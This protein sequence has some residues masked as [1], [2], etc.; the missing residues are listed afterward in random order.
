MATKFGEGCAA[1]ILGRVEPRFSWCINVRDVTAALK[2]GGWRRAQKHPFNGPTNKWTSLAVPSNRSSMGQFVGE[3]KNAK[4]NLKGW[5]L[6]VIVRC[7]QRGFSVNI[8]ERSLLTVRP[9]F[10]QTKTYPGSFFFWSPLFEIGPIEQSEK[11]HRTATLIPRKNSSSV[12]V[13]HGKC[14]SRPRTLANTAG[15]LTR[16]HYA[17][18]YFH[19]RFQPFFFFFK[20]FQRYESF[21]MFPKCSLSTG[22]RLCG[23]FIFWCN[24]VQNNLEQ[25]A[26][27]ITFPSSIHSK[28]SIK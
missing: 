5:T 27:A 19:G 23:E 6:S 22:I 9:S 21:R 28:C 14:L 4:E 3:I 13:E 17:R 7:E 10:L 1:Q 26:P 2:W 18:K 11:H 25:E 15:L 20:Y 12:F 8:I 24:A 16:H